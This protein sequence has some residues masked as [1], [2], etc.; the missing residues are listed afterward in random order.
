MKRCQVFAPEDL[1][2]MSKVYLR[3]GRER[4]AMMTN[5]A[6]K[7]SLAKAVVITYRQRISEA[8][9]AAAALHLVGLKILN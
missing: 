4:P 9:L 8:A 3:A 6:D 2:L 1:S 5:D 7:T